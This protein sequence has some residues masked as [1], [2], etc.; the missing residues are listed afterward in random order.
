MSPKNAVLVALCLLSA[1]KDE[2][3][4]VHPGR[5]ETR[6]VSLDQVE[7]A[8]AVVKEK[9]SL[10]VESAARFS[11]AAPFESSLPA[12]RA[13]AARTVRTDL[14]SPL[15]GKT[16]AF[17][18]SGR[19]PAADL[20]VATSARNLLE[21]EADALADPALSARLGVRCA[22]TLVRVISEVELELVENP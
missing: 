19:I 2:E 13:R 18:P 3:A 9:L 14:P 12:C 7:R 8:Q 11:S 22:P 6:P 15:V 1:A 16:I 20:R 10:V 5:G 17:G 21:L 4:C